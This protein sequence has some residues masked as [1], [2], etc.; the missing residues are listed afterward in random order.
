MGDHPH[1]RK[2]PLAPA[3]KR[4]GLSDDSRS[5]PTHLSS[6]R[7]R[8]ASLACVCCAPSETAPLRPSQRLAAWRLAASE[9]RIDSP[10]LS[11][12]PET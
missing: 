2:R 11:E 8:G 1:G 12:D 7:R 6:S 4:A 5:R 3:G 9:S 10:L